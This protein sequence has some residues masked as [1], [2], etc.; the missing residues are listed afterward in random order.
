MAEGFGQ[1][2]AISITSIGWHT[3]HGCQSHNI[4]GEGKRSVATSRLREGRAPVDGQKD[5]N[6]G[7]VITYAAA[8]QDRRGT[9]F[10]SGLPGVHSMPEL[11]FNSALAGGTADSGCRQKSPGGYD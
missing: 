7:A 10:V 1:D 11:S 4:S 6:T 8:A 3:R 5:G 2:N 9:V